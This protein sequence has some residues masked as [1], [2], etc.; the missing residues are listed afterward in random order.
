MPPLEMIRLLLL[1][2]LPTERLGQASGWSD[3]NMP[4]ISRREGSEACHGATS[5]SMSIG[6]PLVRDRAEAGL[7]LEKMITVRA[8]HP[9][10]ET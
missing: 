1:P 10:D 2:S 7:A 8:P 9:F 5:R 3:S 4:T 6:P